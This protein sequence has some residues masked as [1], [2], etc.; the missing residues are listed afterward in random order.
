M[1]KIK[2]INN[3]N[4]EKVYNLEFQSPDKHIQ[5][6]IYWPEEDKVCF[7]I[8]MNDMAKYSQEFLFS[9]VNKGNVI[10]A[11]GCCGLYPY[12]FS[13]FYERV[14]TFEPD[15]RNFY[16]LTKNCDRDN[17]YKFNAGLSDKPGILK[18]HRIDP[19][20]VGMHKISKH[21]DHEIVTM[22]IDSLGLEECSLIALDIEGH[23]YFALL[24]GIETI[25]KN[26]PVIIL[27]MGENNDEELQN[28]NR[29]ARELLTELGYEQTVRFNQDPPNFIFKPK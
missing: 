8:I 6:E 12:I 10:Q 11:G 20:N 26:K 24:G 3:N 14:Y 5:R 1:E 9:S 27:E 7:P 16:F 2:E 4:N 25:K 19:G 28:K 29:K 21:G 18:F 22:T 13:K 17:I 15:K 23:E